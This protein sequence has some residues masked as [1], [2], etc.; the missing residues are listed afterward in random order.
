MSHLAIA[1]A[2]PPHRDGSAPFLGRESILRGPERP[3]LVRDE[4]LCEIF[5]RSAAFDPN[6]IAMVTR[7]GK[8]TYA[9]VDAK[10]EAIAR[11][12]VRKGLRPGDV[13][14]LWMARG[15]DLL[16]AQIAIAKTGAAWLPFDADAPVERI[17]VCLEDA[18]AKGI[19]RL[20]RFRAQSSK[21]ATSCPAWTIRELI[22]PT[23]TSKVDARAL[24]ATPDSPAYLIYTSGST[25]TPKGIVISGRNICHYLRAANEVYGLRE[26]DVVFQGASVAFDLSMEEI[27]LPY[28]AGATL[29]VATPEVLG[30]AEKLPEIMEANRRHG[31][32]HGADAAG[33]AAARRRHPAGHHSRRRGLP[34]GDRQSLVQAGTAHLQFLRPDRGDGGR[35]RGGGRGRRAGDDRA[36]HPQLQLLCRR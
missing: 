31:A 35:H 11:G 8:L 17:A 19:A 30:E 15:H 10:A 14:G 36:A 1:E 34:A 26:S 5:A 29:F 24:G 12:L 22:D 28:L 20:A 33:A 6:G 7:D 32:R 2:F 3:D 21:D 9:E 18:E 13:A 16:I 4:L 25:G 23:D 27:W